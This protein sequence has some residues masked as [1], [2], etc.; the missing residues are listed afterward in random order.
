MR[1]AFSWLFGATFGLCCAL[2]APPAA[3][4]VD[5]AV[6]H[7]CKGDYLRHCAGLPLDSPDLRRCMR[8]VGENL[9]K[10]CLVALVN[11]GEVTQADIERYQADQAQQTAAPAADAPKPKVQKTASPANGKNTKP[12]REAAQVKPA[13]SKKAGNANHKVAE[14][15]AKKPKRM[16]DTVKPSK[17][18]PATAKKPNYTSVAVSE[19]GEGAPARGFTRKLCQSKRLNGTIAEYVCGIDQRCCMLPLSGQEYCRPEGKPCF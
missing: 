9:S 12:V 16:A 6:S 13:K 10:P 2:A 18:A 11:A 4:A 15:P 19:A 17:A 8:K 5:P 7:A 14:T 3:H 1:N